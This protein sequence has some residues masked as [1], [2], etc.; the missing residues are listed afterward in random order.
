MFLLGIKVFI[1]FTGLNL[2]YF[3]S[4]LRKE[5]SLPVTLQTYHWPFKTLKI[6]SYQ[7]WPQRFDTRQKNDA[8]FARTTTRPS[9]TQPDLTWDTKR[10]PLE[11]SPSSEWPNWI[12]PQSRATDLAQAH[13][14]PGGSVPTGGHGGGCISCNG[15]HLGNAHGCCTA[16]RAA[17][18]TVAAAAGHSYVTAVRTSERE[19]GISMYGA[20]RKVDLHGKGRGHRLAWQG[21]GMSVCQARERNVDVYVKR[22]G[23]FECMARE[24]ER[25]YVWQGSQWIIEFVFDSSLLSPPLCLFPN[26]AFSNPMLHL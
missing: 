7:D 11:V 6:T 10:L 17:S 24:R 20:G 13:R 8:I 16:A 14:F 5:A 2:R 19:R 12:W 15:R 26:H 1:H 22:E 21:R 3:V 9:S 25:L 23:T 4:S 18:A